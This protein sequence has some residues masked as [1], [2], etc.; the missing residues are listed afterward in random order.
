[1]TQTVTLHLTDVAAS[2]LFTA[3]ARAPGYLPTDY[4]FLWDVTVGDVQQSSFD[5]L[6]AAT[7]TL[8]AGAQPFA[9]EENVLLRWDS[10]TAAWVAPESACAA[11]SGWQA[12]TSPATLVAQICRSG[13]YGVFAPAAEIFLPIVAK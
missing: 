9:P 5:L 11:A 10:V 3:T 7:V 12:G 4:G 2:A 6:Q 1:V 13:R 8:T